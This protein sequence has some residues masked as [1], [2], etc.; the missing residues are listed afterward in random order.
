MC[1]LSLHS[2]R[3]KCSHLHPGGQN[4]RFKIS[5]STLVQVCNALGVTVDYILSDEY[6]DSSS[7]LDQSILQELQDC[8]NV[9]KERILKIIQILK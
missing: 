1:G 6:I 2:T 8:D 9:T 4:S 7:P 3:Q 5:L